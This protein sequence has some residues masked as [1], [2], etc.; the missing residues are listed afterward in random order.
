MSLPELSDHYF[1]AIIGSTKRP[2]SSFRL[3]DD[4]KPL[5]GPTWLRTE[6]STRQAPLE[7]FQQS[8]EK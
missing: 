8:L 1:S 3:T 7:H 5:P 4:L 6:L 2:I